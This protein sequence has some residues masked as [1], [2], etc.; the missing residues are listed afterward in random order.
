MDIAAI[1]CANLDP[2]VTYAAHL[3]EEAVTGWEQVRTGFSH[4]AKHPP[5]PGS[6]QV[7]ALLYKEVT[8][9]CRATQARR[10][11]WR[12]LLSSPA[13]RIQHGMELKQADRT[14]TVKRGLVRVSF[15][16][17]AALLLHDLARFSYRE[18]AIAMETT[19]ESASRQLAA[20]RREFGGVFREVSL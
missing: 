2:L 7:R 20:A 6:D 8:R 5:A 11:G 4:F 19:P 12:R 15:D 1:A 10:A 14:N 16:S 3:M 9:A 17:R 18:M 13:A